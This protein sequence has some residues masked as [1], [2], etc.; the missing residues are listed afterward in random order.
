MSALLTD[1]HHAA[2]PSWYAQAPGARPR[3]AR[4]R[5]GYTSTPRTRRLPTSSPSR[6]AAPGRSGRFSVM[7]TGDRNKTPLQ[8]FGL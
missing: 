2:Q 4:P 1:S 6:L 3:P 5:S 7:Q 8:V